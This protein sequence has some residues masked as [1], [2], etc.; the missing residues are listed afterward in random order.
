[1]G[2]GETKK[3]TTKGKGV[4]HRP[5]GEKESDAPCVEAVCGLGHRLMANLFVFRNAGTEAEDRR[6]VFRESARRSMRKHPVHRHVS[7]VLRGSS[8]RDAIHASPRET[9]RSKKRGTAFE[10]RSARSI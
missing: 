1:M 6:D 3:R 5:T 7:H 8:H 2:T 10:V 4:Q 9:C